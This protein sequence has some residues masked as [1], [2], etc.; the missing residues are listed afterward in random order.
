MGGKVN[1]VRIRFG[2]EAAN[3]TATDADR[4]IDE[5]SGAAIDGEVALTENVTDWPLV[6]LADTG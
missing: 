4:C 6:L 1:R 3:G 2:N 5:G